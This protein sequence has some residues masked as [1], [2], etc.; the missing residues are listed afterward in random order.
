MENLPG[1]PSGVVEDAAPDAEPGSPIAKLAIFS[2]TFATVT[3]TAVV[4]D[5]PPTTSVFPPSPPS[6]EAVPPVKEGS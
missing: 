4:W 6:P 2:D 3:S 5:T 1:G